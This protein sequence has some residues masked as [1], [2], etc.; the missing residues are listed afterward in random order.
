MID[1]NEMPVYHNFAQETENLFIESAPRL[2]SLTYY[3]PGYGFTSYLPCDFLSHWI[4][5]GAP[6]NGHLTMKLLGYGPVI[7]GDFRLDIQPSLASMEQIEAFLASIQ[8][9]TLC[10]HYVGWSSALYHGL[11]E[12]DISFYSGF[13]QLPTT[14]E[15]AAIL[16]ASPGLRALKLHGFGLQSQDT[17]NTVEPIRL[18]YLEVL[19]LREIHRRSLGLLLPMIWPGTIPLYMRFNVPKRGVDIVHYAQFLQRSS[20]VKLMIV[21]NGLSLPRSILASLAGVRCLCLCKF[22]LDVSF[23]MSMHESWIPY[24]NEQYPSV[25]PSLQILHLFECAFH[26]SEHKRDP[27][28][29]IPYNFMWWIW[30]ADQSNEMDSS[31]VK[32]GAQNVL[33]SFSSYVPGMQEVQEDKS[34][35]L[36]AWGSALDF[37]PY[38]ICSA[39]S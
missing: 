37:A 7:S 17:L 2:R 33:G 13:A 5:H 26:I 21:G 30:D 4:Q 36:E 1:I 15:F 11:I 39:Q 31:Y 22:I 19:F 25:W 29:P 14:T 18:D 24:A 27:K 28:K 16:S 8:H 35:L 9:L 32:R 20:V 3:S 10:N 23:W 34:I 12:L 6:G 38:S